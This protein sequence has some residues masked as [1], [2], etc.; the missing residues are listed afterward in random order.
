MKNSQSRLSVLFSGIISFTLSA[1]GFSSCD[2]F[3]GN[4]GEGP[5]I[6]MYGTPSA[7]FKITGNVVSEESLQ[8]VKDLKIT[9]VEFTTWKDGAGIYYEN[10]SIDSL[11]TKTNENGSFSFEYTGFPSSKKYIY[12]IEDVDDDANGRFLTKKDS[13]L[14]TNPQYTGKDKDNSW[15][16]GEAKKDFGT[17]K[18]KPDKGQ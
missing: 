6:C 10:Q 11:R 16:S 9:L 2:D 12:L 15:Y 4:N 5:I 17:I 3:N 14:F 1:L 13:I 18:V 8:P 7:K